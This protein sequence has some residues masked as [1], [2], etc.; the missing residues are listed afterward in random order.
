[1][2]M[3][4]RLFLGLFFCSAAFAQAVQETEYQY[5]DRLAVEAGA[6]KSTLFHNY[7]EVYADYFGKIRD[8]KLTF[9][10]IGIY[11]GA[12]V[13]LWEKYFP[14]ADL[15]F[16][17]ITP[18]Y[19]K[20]SSDRSKYHFIDQTDRSGLQAMASAYGPFDI[21]IDDGGHTMEQQLTS[22]QELFS[23]VKSGGMYIIE[24]LHTSYWQLF[25]G[26]GTVQQPLA[27]PGT[28]IHVLKDLI[29]CMNYTGAFTTCADYNK[30]PDELRSQFN[31]YQNNIK[32]MHF[33]GS[34][35]IIIKR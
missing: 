14:N 29:D 33:H 8:R 20:Y 30:V 7:T 18:A 32:A 15:H 11:E 16:I 26:N 17:D 1:M 4:L 12:S 2:K 3:Y 9:L 35:C 25:G 10:E 21:I 34:M 31:Y 22:F 23:H 27:G 24:D 5:L 13:K 19:I 28:M 6:D